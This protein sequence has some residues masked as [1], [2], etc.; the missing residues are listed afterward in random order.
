M[1]VIPVVF[2]ADNNYALYTYVA[3]LSALENKDKSTIYKFYLLVPPFFEENYKGKFYALCKK[4]NCTVQIINMKDT[5]ATAKQWSY[6]TTPVYY[7]LIIDQIITDDKCIYLDCDVLVLKDLSELF[8]IDIDDFYAA[9]VLDV[10]NK[11]NPSYITKYK[12]CEPMEYINAGVLL[13]NLRKI[14]ENKISEEI[15]Q[16]FGNKKFIKKSK[17]VDQDIINKAYR[18]NIKYIS[19]RFNF[20]NSIKTNEF[21]YFQA[22][23]IFQEIE[24]SYNDVSVIHF[25]GQ[26]KPWNSFINCNDKTIK[27]WLKYAINS[28]LWKEIIE[29]S[30]K[31]YTRSILNVNKNKIKLFFQYFRYKLLR[32]ICTG[33]KKLHYQGKLKKINCQLQ[34]L[35]QLLEK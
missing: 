35:K 10:L 2:A 31:Q 14:R 34:L 3:V 9:G 23:K 17:F 1:T 15:Q 30:I 5:F 19:L 16:L 29:S 18:K 21:L 20:N 8:E 11:N 28:D 12:I 25:A 6:F 24:Q 13:L 4:Y 33:N 22:S 32:N 7:R 26:E 27:I